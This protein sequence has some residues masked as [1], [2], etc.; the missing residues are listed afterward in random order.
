[1]RNFSEA[2]TSSKTA[3]FLTAYNCS[4]ADFVGIEPA[5]MDTNRIRRCLG[6]ISHRLLWADTASQRRSH[7][8]DVNVGQCSAPRKTAV[9]ASAMVREVPKPTSRCG[10]RRP[11]CA[12]ARACFS[13]LDSTLYWRAAEAVYPEVLDVSG[14]RAFVFLQALEL[15]SVRKCSSAWSNQ[16]DSTTWDESG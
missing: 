14:R 13:I 4:S 12:C 9:L 6:K 15:G 10:P 2:S 3:N 8:I 7:R 1:M 16:E 11:S 5:E